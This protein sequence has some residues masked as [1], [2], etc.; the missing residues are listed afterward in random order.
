[1]SQQQLLTNFYRYF[2]NASANMPDDQKWQALQEMFSSYGRELPDFEGP[3]QY[4]QEVDDELTSNF[5]NNLKQRIESNKSTVPEKFQDFTP[6]VFNSLVEDVSLANYFAEHGGPLGFGSSDFYK[7]VYNHQQAGQ[8]YTTMYGK[9]RY[10]VSDDYKPNALEHAAGFFLSLMSPLDLLNLWGAGKAGVAAKGAVGKGLLNKW[11]KESVEETTENI[12]KKKVGRYNFARGATE[13]GTNLATFTAGH[14]A[15]GSAA[16]Q[17]IET[18]DV[19]FIKVMGDASHAALESGIVGALTGGPVKG[20]MATSYAY[21]KM[22]ENPALK[23]KLTKMLTHPVSQVGTEAAAFTTIPHLLNDAGIPSLTGLFESTPGFTSDNFSKEDYYNHLISNAGIIGS[24][25][26]YSSLKGPRD[27]DIID[28]V[29]TV[30]D[31]EKSAIG[32]ETASF[33]AMR[34]NLLKQGFT[35]ED[36]IREITDLKTKER[37]IAEDKE[38]IV[39]VLQRIQSL[40]KKGFDNLDKSEK[41]FLLEYGIIG[42]GHSAVRQSITEFLR[43]KDSMFEQLEKVLSEKTGKTVKLGERDRQLW[44]KEMEAEI[45]FMDLIKEQANASAVGRE[46]LFETPFKKEDISIINAKNDFGNSKYFIKTKDNNKRLFEDLEFNTKEQA[47]EY[48]DFWFDNMKRELGDNW[49][50]QRTSE[51][52]KLTPEDVKNKLKQPLEE[53]IEEAKKKVAKEEGIGDVE[54]ALEGET[55]KMGLIDAGTKQPI[56][57][58]RGTDFYTIDVPIKDVETYRNKGYKTEAEIKEGMGG[59]GV[60]YRPGV[61]DVP[62]RVKIDYD[63]IARETAEQIKFES[64][65]KEREKFQ[66][67]NER[68]I[69]SEIQENKYKISNIIRQ[70]R[71]ENKPFSYIFK[72]QH[73]LNIRDLPDGPYKTILRTTEWRNNWDNLPNGSN[74]RKFVLYVID[75]NPKLAGEALNFADF[76]V[77]KLR[78]PM[79]KISPIDIN[80]YLDAANVKMNKDLVK[81]FGLD[82]SKTHYRNVVQAAQTTKFGDFKNVIREFYGKGD[83]AWG[84]LAK[85]NKDKIEE[86]FSSVSKEVNEQIKEGDKGVA[87]PVIG[88]RKQTLKIGKELAKDRKNI[89][90][91]LAAELGAKYLIRRQEINNLTENFKEYG[92]VVKKEGENYYLDLKQGFKKPKTHNRKV[93]IEPKFA[94]DLQ[95]FIS[96]GKSLKGLHAEIGK[97]LNETGFADTRAS[98]AFGDLRHRGKS[99][100]IDSELQY[101]NI[102]RV[103]WM[104]GHDVTAIDLIYAKKSTAQ[105]LSDQKGFYDVGLKGLAPYKSERYQRSRTGKS[106]TIEEGATTEWLLNQIKKNRGPRVN[107]QAEDVGYAGKYYKG[108][109]DIVLGK[110]DMGTW[111]HENAH[112]FQDYIY[113]VGNK[114]LIKLWETAESRFKQDAKKEGY[115]KK[116]KNPKEAMDE[117]MA[118]KISEWS[119]KQEMPRSLRQRMGNFV[120][121]LWS[122]T[123]Q[124]LFGKESLNERDLQRILGEKVWKGFETGKVKWGEMER[125]QQIDVGALEKITN[126][127]FRETMKGSLSEGQKFTDAQWKDLRKSVAL[128]AGI[129]NPEGFAFKHAPVEDLYAFRD[130]LQFFKGGRKALAIHAAKEI[131]DRAKIDAARISKGITDAEQANILKAIG[132]K[133]GKVDSA[134]ELQFKIYKETV[135]RMVLDIPTKFKDNIDERINSEFLTN[136]AFKYAGNVLPEFVVI[137]KLGLKNLSSKLMDHVAVELENSRSFREFENFAINSTGVGRKGWEGSSFKE[138]ISDAMWTVDHQRY[139]ERRDAKLLTKFQEKFVKKAFTE[140]YVNAKEPIK[141][142]DIN[143]IARKTVEGN[144]VR[145]YHETT[146]K[147][148]DMFHNVLKENLNKAEY[149]K[150]VDENN[151]KWIDEGIYFS[152]G[153]S[154]EFKKYF[155]PE[156]TASERFVRSEAEKIEREI[157]ANEFKN[158]KITDEMYE[159]IKD[160]AYSAAEMNFINAQ[161]FGSIKFNSPYLLGRHPKLPERIYVPEAGKFV[162]VYETKW[163]GTGKKYFL[164]MSKLLA[165]ME[166]FP[167]YVNIKGTN[168]P[169]VKSVISKMGRMSPQGK[170]YEAWVNKAVEK[171]LGISETG[172]PFDIIATPFEKTAGFI[173]KTQLAFPTSAFKNLILGNQ[174]TLST[175]W[176]RDFVYGLMQTLSK[177]NR[178]D[179]KLGGHTDVGIRHLDKSGKSIKVVE[180]MFELGGMKLSEDVNRYI[181]VFAGKNHFNRTVR[182]LQ[183]YKEGT[184][185]HDRV[186]E[187]LE[188]FYKMDKNQINLLKKYGTNGV[189]TSEKSMG[190]IS[191]IERKLDVIYQKANTLAHINTQGASLQLFMPQRAGGRLI[192][193]LTLYKR[194]AYAATTNTLRNFKDGAKDIKAGRPGGLVKIAMNALGPYLA[195]ELLIGIHYHLLGTEP[196]KENSDWMT[197]LKAK[198][199]K[200]EMFGI[201]SEVFSPYADKGVARSTITPAL[202]N[203]VHSIGLHLLGLSEGHK[204]WGQFKEDVLKQTF[205]AYNGYLKIVR[206]TTTPERLIFDKY[207]KLYKDFEKEMDVPKTANYVEGRRSETY[208]DIVDAWFADGV[209]ED[210]VKLLLSHQSVLEQQYLEEYEG[211]KYTRTEAREQAFK[212]LQNLIENQLHPNPALVNKKQSATTIRIRTQFMKWLQRE[213]QLKT[214]LVPKKDALKELKEA[215]D[216]HENKVKKLLSTWKRM[217]KQTGL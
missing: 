37:A 53:A 159:Q 201:L 58:G 141:T 190:E 170:E 46:A 95:D 209:S 136:K 194:M 70:S 178:M 84:K 86:I 62:Q 183:R 204:S 96:Q 213:P 191:N 18:G 54:A 166:L 98:Q 216:N 168:F 51:E 199:W 147:V 104:M 140:E 33:Q 161:N 107:I 189:S 144:I 192:K 93:L 34:E 25:R 13:L 27:R 90:Y 118:D 173:A 167:E 30:M 39:P 135:S 65:R 133:D 120:K 44:I 63:R 151:V 10:D 57:T 160:A 42:D 99:V 21:A 75:K 106:P 28:I 69:D 76:M 85:E 78:R 108:A 56:Y 214:L 126:K 146:L 45:E 82:P 171:Q 203:W 181:S 186:K 83:I 116:F 74:E 153:L 4:H 101:G 115:Y 47:Q 215:Q 92:N 81:Y 117:F 32:K 131:Q 109:I 113:S 11:A 60:E 105:I 24:M 175:Y 94:K 91:S 148:K 128:H 179:V 41:R 72:R 154:K 68:L 88:V 64:E 123:K 193:P 195:G 139:I 3:L 187:T 180:K 12:L 100:Y 127:L 132:V 67:V 40:S 19:D 185:S 111:F 152:R 114:E 200:G 31:V 66:T 29:K 71:Q 35:A 89:G 206:K 79:D 162:E 43:N 2:P 97:K 102:E 163:E 158:K 174:L 172:D 15:L 217:K 138:G 208:R 134:N 48:A 49:K 59:T 188:T 184:R 26:M 142:D 23:H 122:K 137:E 182:G 202:Y 205:S 103:K 165:N 212:Y 145:K 14:A 52:I 130:A 5:A 169:G 9:E 16:Q 7:H 20:T 121:R 149:E 176:M 77:N 210:F 73:K 129:E 164:S 156:S 119:L 155:T 150:W 55:V 1:M 38:Y 50:A 211:K 125:F 124:A 207:N 143:K 196:P 22:A 87:P 6:D 177:E 198:L 8:W 157:I 36:V 110:A 17:R 197:A 80:K 61:E 112:R